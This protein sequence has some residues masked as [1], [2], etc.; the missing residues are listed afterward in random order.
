MRLRQPLARRRSSMRLDWP[1]ISPSRS[2]GWPRKGLSCRTLGSIHLRREVALGQSTPGWQCP[3]HGRLRLE[4]KK[5]ATIPHESLWQRRQEQDDTNTEKD[6]VFVQEFPGKVPGYRV[7]AQT[8]FHH[9]GCREEERP[10][11]RKRTNSH[12]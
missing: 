2:V 10:R 8:P 5:A 12:Q 11:N 1:W 3:L 9:A 6:D 7:C 4:R